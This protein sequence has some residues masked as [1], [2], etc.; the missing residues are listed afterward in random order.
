MIN[1]RAARI[2]VQR[3]LSSLSA[4][5]GLGRPSSAL[6]QRDETGGQP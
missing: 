4:V 1:L 6:A 5:Q 2:S 3:S